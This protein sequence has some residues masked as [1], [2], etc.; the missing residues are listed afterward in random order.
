MTAPPRRYWAEMTTDEVAGWA[1]SQSIAIL[2][3]GAIEQHGPHLPLAVDA[4]IADAVVR[5]AVAL[6]PATLP[7]V[8][9]PQM[10]LGYSREHEGFAGTLSLSAATLTGLW[11]EIGA[12]VARTGVRKLV[13]LNGHG[14]NPPVMDIVARELR[15]AHDMLVVVASWFSLGLPD[16]LFTADEIQH[17][18]H[19]GAVE[20]SVML[21]LHPELVQVEKAGD[22]DSQN[23]T[24]TAANDVLALEG[25]IRC[26]WMAQ[27]LNPQGVAGAAGAADAVAG[28]RV[29]E[30]AAGRLITLLEEVNRL[31]LE[32]LKAGP[33]VQS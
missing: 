33:Q 12:S 32:T 9:L 23:R 30:H 25:P 20:T 2:P 14:G 18:I 19:G 7:A 22:F 1:G 28:Q 31:P 21:Y 10:P 29:V 11:L 6:M 24:M 17:G 4:T 16:G 26:G 8:V 13:L 27:D 15:A 3:V 5:H